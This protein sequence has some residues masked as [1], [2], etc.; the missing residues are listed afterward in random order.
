MPDHLAQLLLTYTTFI[1]EMNENSSLKNSLSLIST[2]EE[3][4][5]STV[6]TNTLV[7]RQYKIQ[8][9]EPISKSLTQGISAA[10]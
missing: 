7:K 3:D 5:F 10:K 9:I 4:R 6:T 2:Q 1:I 8:Q